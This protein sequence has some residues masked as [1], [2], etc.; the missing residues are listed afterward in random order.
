M[1]RGRKNKPTAQKKLEGNPGKR[2]LNDKE[3][4]PD[5]VIPE[6]PK[7]LKGA[8]REE[9]DR[10]TVE[11]QALGIISNIDRAALVAYCTA[12]GDYVYACAKLNEPDEDDVI[13]SIKGGRYQNPWVAIKTGAMDRLVRYAAEFGMTP[14]S[15]ARIKVETPSEEDKMASFLF[16]K[17]TRVTK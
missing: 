10:I 7:H 6:C 17:Q 15:R 9:W 11:L 14:A 2:E 1:T 5:V 8:A 12:W 3:P 4:Q 16:R 13:T